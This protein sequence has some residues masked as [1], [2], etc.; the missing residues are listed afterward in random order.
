MDVAAGA[1]SLVL[2]CKDANAPVLKVPLELLG[3]TCNSRPELSTTKP[4]LSVENEPARVNAWAPSSS[5]IKNPSP[6]TAKS[7]LLEVNS[8][9]P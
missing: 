8:I 7:K 6:L 4:S 3:N 1:E 2:N 9:L 5:T